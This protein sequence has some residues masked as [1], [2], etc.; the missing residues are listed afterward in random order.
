M[1]QDLGQL[2]EARPLAERA[3]AIDQAAY[4]P[5]HPAVATLRTN[6][7]VIVADLEQRRGIKRSRATS[8]VSGTEQRQAQIEGNTD[9]ST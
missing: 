8:E 7:A 3:L 9:G 2:A 6:L 4:G 1:L 5:D